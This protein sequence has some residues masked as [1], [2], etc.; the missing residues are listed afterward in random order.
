MAE[1]VW[2][3]QWAYVDGASIKINS[4]PAVVVVLNDAA[5]FEKHYFIVIS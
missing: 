5:L 4:L 3:G 1:I 2:K